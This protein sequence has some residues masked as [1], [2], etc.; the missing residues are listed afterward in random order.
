M[1]LGL[2]SRR[3]IWDVS[4]WKTPRHG[5]SVGLLLLRRRCGAVTVSGFN[6]SLFCA[7]PSCANKNKIKRNHNITII[8]LFYVAVYGNLCNKIQLLWLCSATFRSAMDSK[9][10]QL[11]PLPVVVVHFIVFY[12]I[13]ANPLVQM[14]TQSSTLDEERHSR[15]CCEML[16]IICYRTWWPKR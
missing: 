15:R 5:H 16:F 8:L 1:R 10:S 7:I 11:R 2:S 14:R 4:P 12:C 6:T 9:W 3:D 13:C